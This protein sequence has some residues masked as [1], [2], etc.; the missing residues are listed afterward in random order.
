MT[1]KGREN[2]ES[3]NEAGEKTS[4]ELLFA[5]I[6]IVFHYTQNVH[7]RTQCQYVNQTEMYSLNRWRCCCCWCCFRFSML[8]FTFED[9][10]L[11]EF[12]QTIC[13]CNLPSWPVFSKCIRTG[14]FAKPCHANGVLTTKYSADCAS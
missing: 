9:A 7:H 12:F 1:E 6:H 14:L 3:E 4:I 11:N 8:R 2:K 13:A 5:L 10:K